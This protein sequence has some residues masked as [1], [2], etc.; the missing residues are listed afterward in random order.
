MPTESFKL[1]LWRGRKEIHRSVDQCIEQGHERV[2]AYGH[3]FALFSDAKA[4]HRNSIAS[5]IA[6]DLLARNIRTELNPF[7]NA[8]EQ[9]IVD[10][11]FLCLAIEERR[12]EF[13]IL[14]ELIGNTVE[15]K[16]AYASKIH[17]K[18]LRTNVNKSL[19]KLRDAAN[20]VQ[21]PETANLQPDSKMMDI[22]RTLPKPALRA[23]LNLLIHIKDVKTHGDHKHSNVD[24]LL[25]SMRL[26]ALDDP[27]HPIEDLIVGDGRVGDD[28]SPTTIIKMDPWQL[29]NLEQEVRKLLG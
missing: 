9:L 25:D 8:A 28:D 22:L 11:S 19:D 23:L 27:L 6:D 29:K 26:S 2:S 16:D 7:M 17:N 4:G 5:A 13:S 12:E 21:P 1:G 3:L 18:P 15:M 14:L 10:G 20:A 24:E